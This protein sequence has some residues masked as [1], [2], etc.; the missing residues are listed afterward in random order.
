MPGWQLTQDR[1]PDVLANVFAGQE[2][3]WADA[4]FDAKVH[5]VQFMQ[6]MAPVAE[7]VHGS[8]AEQLAA[9]VAAYLPGSQVE[10]EEA[11]ASE[12]DPGEQ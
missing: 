5:G 8:H 12:N 3:H 6:L 7:Y 2:P 4:E 11:H 10:Q 1:E 9:P